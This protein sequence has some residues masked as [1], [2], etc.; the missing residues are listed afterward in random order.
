MR[1]TFVA[2]GWENIS[3]EYL[4]AFLKNHS[5]QISIAYDQ[6]LFD[7]KNYVCIP[8]L[9]KLF[10]Q[11]ENCLRQIIDSKPDLVAFSVMTVTFQWALGMAG[12]VKRYMDVP[13]IFG[14]AHPSSVP[15]TVIVKDPVDM[16]CI[17]EGDE[18]LL[19]LCN[20][21]ERKEKNYEIKNIW[22]KENGR[23]IRNERRVQIEDLNKLPLLDKELF[24]RHVPIKN[25][26]IAVIARGCP[27][28]CSYCNVSLEAREYRKIKGKSIRERTVDN[29][30]LELKT[31]HDRYKYRWIDFRNS[32]F[33]ISENWTVEFCKRYRKEI[34]LPF[35][36][37]SHPSLIWSDRTAIALRDA[38]CFAVQIGLES[39]DEKLRYEVLNRR[40][41]NEQIYRAVSILERNR[42]PYSLDYILG[43]PGQ[44]EEECIKAAEFFSGL[45][46]CYRIS[47]FMCQY[48]PGLDLI[49]YG[50]ELN[51]LNKEDIN[52][53]NE[54]FHDNY[55]AKGSLTKERA[56]L[57][58]VYKIFFRS[59]SFMPVWLKSFIVKNRFYKIL[60]IAPGFLSLLIKVFDIFILI[61]DID[62]RTYFYNYCWWFS[63]RFNPRHPSFWFYGRKYRKEV[64]RYFGNK[65]YL[66]D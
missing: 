27:F 66:Y 3:I 22:F 6:A 64:K 30:I 36:I 9:Y 61:R 51:D 26:Y 29:V 41:S 25:Y 11:K 15:E 42:L 17:G 62:A 49:K 43:I 31:M 4:S 53:I 56:K 40:V 34:G 35:R 33:S 45:K 28:H 38:G 44:K 52:R 46:Y 23:I 7:D 24:S 48:L 50:R 21:I 20:S 63:R 60:K 37:F 14:G 2:T 47:P 19:E 54:G 13:V 18:A 32:V 10:D 12:L 57:F 39:F 5:H 1:I 8:W 16:I 55:M 65:Q 58:I 59:M